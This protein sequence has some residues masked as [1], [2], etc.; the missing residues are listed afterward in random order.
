M[1]VQTPLLKFVLVA[2]TS[3]DDFERFQFLSDGDAAFGESPLLTLPQ[4]AARLELSL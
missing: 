4:T 1:L 3:R 2:I